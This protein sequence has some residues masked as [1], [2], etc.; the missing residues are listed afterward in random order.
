MI[1]SRNKIEDTRQKVDGLFRQV[2]LTNED[3]S[4]IRKDM[5]RQ[6]KDVK[7]LKKTLTT[8]QGDIAK[9]QQ[10]LKEEMAAMK[11]ILSSL[12]DALAITRK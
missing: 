12:H 11:T 3:L 2:I 9:Y 6:E 5:T 4:N 10:D 1:Q 7:E 8:V